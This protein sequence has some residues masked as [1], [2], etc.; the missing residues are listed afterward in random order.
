MIILSLQKIKKSFGGKEVLADVSFSLQ[1]GRRMAI[2]GVNGSGKST[3]LKI[4]AGLEEADSGL[5]T[6]AKSTTI[7]FLE[8]HGTFT[9][10][11]SVYQVAK[12]SLA[13]ILQLE[14]QLRQMEVDISFIENEEELASLGEKYHQLT[15]V[16][17]KMDGY[18]WQ[19]NL[20]GVLTGLGFSKQQFDQPANL[21]SGGEQTRLRLAC[22]L[23]EKPSLLL[24]DEPTNHLD[25]QA[26]GWLEGYLQKYNGTVLIV[27]HDR[28]FLDRVCN[29]ITEIL[30]GKSETY[31]NKTYSS[32]LIERNQRMESRLKAFEMQQKEIERQKEIIARYRRFNR[33]KSIRAAESREKQLAKIELLER[34][35]E[36]KEIHFSFHAK[37]RSGNDVLKINELSKAFDEKPLFKNIS[38]DVKRGMRI[39]ILGPNGIGKTTFFRCVLGFS[40]P[41]SG[42]VH[43]GTNVLVGYYDQKQEQLHPQ[44]T[45]LQEVWDE[46]PHLEQTQIRN[47]L[48]SFLLTGD[49]VFQTISSLSGGEKGRVIFTKLILQEDNLLLLDE[50]TNHLDMDSREMLELALENYEGTILAISHDRY[51][52]NRFA[53]HI[54]YMSDNA[55]TLFQGNY[56][57]YLAVTA[58]ENDSS[59]PEEE[60]K[61]KTEILKEKKK[62]RLQKAEEK[63]LKEKTK[64]LEKDIVDQETLLESLE[65]QLSDSELYK[66]AEKSQEVSKAYEQTKEKINLLYQLWEE[67]LLLIEE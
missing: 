3:L 16:F 1:E 52:I 5:I 45:V 19:S 30:L 53:T 42:S 67:A 39:A 32:F 48:G 15:Q 47:T 34:P 8:Q 31:E 40:T 25:L 2:V 58:K 33:E 37:K 27:S 20:T 35:E 56:D 41:D 26:I 12:K 10:D 49:D 29:D 59:L 18:A 38:L 17:E 51:F 23:L 9:E 22:L 46:F 21:L 36:E 14:K 50:P 66:D 13:T 63:A 43:F 28:Y 24:L 7:G 65:M 60:G 62:N 55:I 11:T 44:K 64:A 57:D 61:T 4:I 6:K 54:G